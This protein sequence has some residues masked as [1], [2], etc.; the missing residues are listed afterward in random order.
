MWRKL[1]HGFLQIMT[2]T[3]PR[4]VKPS[5]TERLQLIWIFR[6]FSFLPQQVLS[7]REQ[8]LLS[9]LCSD[10]R[11]SSNGPGLGDDGELIGTVLNTVFPSSRRSGDRRSEER[12]PTQFEVRYGVGKDL[13]AGE[14]RDLAGGGIG[15]SGPKP[16]PPGTELELHYRLVPTAK[17]TRA[18]VLIRH[19]H[20]N[21][22]GAEVLKLL[23]PS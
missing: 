8:H 21:R 2:D 20:G 3:G 15:F 7:A 1:S 9:A 18:R 17:W 5:F 12:C 4:Y 19:C 22:M 10:G 16:Y 14:G 11:L 23:R 13:I 6:N